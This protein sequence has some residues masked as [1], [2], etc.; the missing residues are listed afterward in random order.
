MSHARE[1]YVLSTL[2]AH[3]M[4]TWYTRRI[5]S[6]DGTSMNDRQ[7]TCMLSLNGAE[8]QHTL[9]R[10]QGSYASSSRSV[11]TH[12]HVP[13]YV[14][15]KKLL[16]HYLLQLLLQ[17]SYLA[18]TLLPSAN[19]LC[20][21]GRQGLL[22]AFGLHRL[23]LGICSS[24]LCLMLQRILL[25]FLCQYL[26][27]THSMSIFG[28]CADMTAKAVTTACLTWCVLILKEPS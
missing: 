4:V 26:P 22:I 9:P 24:S 2:S 19:L 28:K 13:V 5:A 23:L 14:Y 1:T 10:S 16:R 8:R 18:L 21:K 7:H 6:V 15:L 20:I 3:M 12:A 27:C 11:S 17:T 25:A